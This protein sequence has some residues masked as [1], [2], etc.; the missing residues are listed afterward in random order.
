MW[1]SAL[2]VNVPKTCNKKQEKTVTVIHE[3]SRPIRR[4]IRIFVS[5]KYDDKLSIRKKINILHRQGHEITYDWTRATPTKNKNDMIR[6][7]VLEVLA[8]KESDI[9]VVILND[10]K[11]TYRGTFAELGCSVGLG[12]NIMIYHKPGKSPFM[13]SHFYNH[14]LVKHFTSWKK[15]LRAIDVSNKL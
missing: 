12:K 15:L 14:P 7:A 5:G 9:H 13:N 11:Y 2:S 4:P 8:I 10:N 3:N 1:R 6:K